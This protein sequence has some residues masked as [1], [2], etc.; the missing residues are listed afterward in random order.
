MGPNGVL[1]KHG[2][3]VKETFFPPP[4]SPVTAVARAGAAG[5]QPGGP[6]QLLF[7]EVQPQ[8][9]AVAGRPDGESPPL[10]LFRGLSGDFFCPV[11]LSSL[12]TGMPLGPA[13]QP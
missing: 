8:D 3:Q 9:G 5:A 4:Y 7:P 10:L 6:L 2:L 12:S 11:R 13:Y 1:R